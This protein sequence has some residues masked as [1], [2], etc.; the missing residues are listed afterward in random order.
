MSPPPSGP[1]RE[2]NKA[3]E[4]GGD[5][6]KPKHFVEDIL[7]GLLICVECTEVASCETVCRLKNSTFWDVTL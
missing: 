7:L 2:S 1:L 4:A 6:M 5:L 3:T